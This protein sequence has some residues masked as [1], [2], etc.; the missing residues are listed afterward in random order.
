MKTKW[1]MSALIVV[2]AGALAYGVSRHLACR[3][4]PENGLERLRDVS[5]LQRELNL[6]D[7]QVV[8]IKELRQDLKT[9]LDACMVRHCGA[10]M[11]LAEALGNGTNIQARA[12]ALLAAMC[13]A[14]EDSERATLDHILRVRALLDTKQQLQF[15]ALLSACLCQSCERGT[16]DCACM[17]TSALEEQ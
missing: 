5:F 10:R 16:S 8:E 3:L 12:D 4:T 9:Q 7:E 2:A 14:Y 1:M 17:R 6:T 15:D 13:R 11:Q